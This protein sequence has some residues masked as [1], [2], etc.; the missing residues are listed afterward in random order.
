MSHVAR[1]WVVLAVLAGCSSEEPGA[2]SHDAASA[3]TTAADDGLDASSVTSGD[4]T[5]QDTVSVAFDSSTTDVIVGTDVVDGSDG[6]TAIDAATASADGMDASDGSSDSASTATDA[7]DGTDGIDGEVTASDGLVDASDGADTASTTANDGT[8]GVDGAEGSTE[9]SL[10][11]GDWVLA[12]GE[13]ST[14]CVE[15][16]LTNEEPILITSITTTLNPGSHHLIVYRL[17]DGPEN[18]NPYPCA[19]FA[20]GVSGTEFPLMISEI[21]N[22]T[23]QFKAGVGL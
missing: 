13:E 17:E 23:F 19:P 15:K 7:A 6:D 16:R 3:S 14:R 1:Y 11:I 21:P 10:F 8:D 18:P 2:A 12:P 5:A 9:Y 22:E 20:G 4:T